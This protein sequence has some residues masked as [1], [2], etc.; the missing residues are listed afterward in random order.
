MVFRLFWKQDS[1]EEK[2]SEEAAVIELVGLHQ[3]EIVTV[4]VQVHY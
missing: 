4:Q 2:L 3:R 1:M